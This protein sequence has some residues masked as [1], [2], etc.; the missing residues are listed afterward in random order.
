[1]LL[2]PTRFLDLLH[3]FLLTATILII[4]CRT[5]FWCSFVV[6]KSSRN[7]REI[8]RSPYFEAP[9]FASIWS[10]FKIKKVLRP[11]KR[12]RKRTSNVIEHEKPRSFSGNQFTYNAENQMSTVWKRNIFFFCKKRTLPSAKYI[13][14]GREEIEIEDREENEVNIMSIRHQSSFDRRPWRN[15]RERHSSSFSERI[16]CCF[17]SRKI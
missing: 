1:M 16:C 11:R 12:K 7:Q 9:K 13:H 2:N 8:R 17:N 6:R 5:Y 15:K 3:N 14:F 4:L 10:G